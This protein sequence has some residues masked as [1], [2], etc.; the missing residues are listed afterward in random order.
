M[1]LLL[2]GKV[3]WGKSDLPIGCEGEKWPGNNGVVGQVDCVGEK[4]PGNWL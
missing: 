2:V 4:G 1:K 3:V